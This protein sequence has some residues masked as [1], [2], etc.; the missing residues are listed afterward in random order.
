MSSLVEASIH[1][2]NKLNSGVVHFYYDI[3]KN[4]IT[5]AGIEKLT[6]NEIKQAILEL[7][8]IVKALEKEI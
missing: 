2:E 6:K 7:K 3:E 1:L 5:F 4:L 8:E